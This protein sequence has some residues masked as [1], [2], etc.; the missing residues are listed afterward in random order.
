[1]GDTMKN[2]IWAISTALFAAVTGLAG[3]AWACSCAF[4]H[5][6][7][8]APADGA[9]DVPTNARIWVGAQTFGG[10]DV[11]DAEML[12]VVRD[13]AGDEVAVTFGEVY[14]NNQLVAVLTPDEPLI[15]DET[16]SIELLDSG[17]VLGTFTAGQGPDEDDPDVPVE[18]ERHAEV[19]ERIANQ[20]SS[21]GY[22]DIVEIT[23]DFDGVLV[24]ANITGM[25]D[26]DPGAVDGEASDVNLDGVL[27]IG[28]AGCI[29]SWPDAEPQATT[30]LQWGT[31]DIAGNFSGW[32]APT[33][34]ELP[35]AGCGC[36]AT[37]SNSGP[38]AAL[39]LALLIACWLRLR[40]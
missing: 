39:G 35:S 10:Q 11:D 32:S 40:R 3:T 4:N 2:T 6:E 26:L 7:L 9:E 37:G 25:D 18:L 20:M 34:I 36:D 29:W 28:S 38:G 8:L 24:V 12:L 33:T 19:S 5:T 30:D 13:G 15:P 31:F 1:M 27:V 23:V 17:E 14:G 16:Y 22:T 21:C